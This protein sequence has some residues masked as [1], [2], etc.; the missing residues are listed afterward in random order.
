MDADLGRV[1]AGRYRLLER[2]GRGGMG[3][4]WHAHDDQLDRDVAVKEL[5]LPEHLTAPEREN[6]IARL[7]REAR[8]AAR[9]KHPGIITVH[10][11]MVSE[12]GRPWIVME[13]VRGGSLADLLASRERL[14]PEQAAR[15][16]LQVL[17]SL[18]AA[19]QAGITHRDV[20]PANILLEQDRVVLTDFGIAAVDGDAT[21]TASGVLLGTPAFMAPEQVRGLPATPASDLWSLGATLYAAVQGHPPFEGAN[22]GAVLV[23]VATEEPIPTTLA[24]PLE[25]TLRGLL[26]KDPAQRLTHAQ[27]HEL[28][29]RVA[30]SSAYVPTQLDASG[31]P[32]GRTTPTAGTEPLL[33]AKPAHPPLVP[34]H[35]PAPPA[36]RRKPG[37]A[38][39]IT[40]VVLLLAVGGGLGGYLLYGHK[41]ADEDSP[42]YKAN[43]RAA[44][45]MG[46]PPGFSRTSETKLGGDKVRE[47][48]TTTA[49]CG[50]CT[51]QTRTKA[52]TDWLKGQPDVQAV[53][54]Y[55]RGYRTEEC[56]KPGDCG[57]AVNSAGHPHLGSGQWYVKAGRL[58]FQIDVG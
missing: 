27:L 15:I 6:W 53:I 22:S 4:V 11:R 12:D 48:Y 24:G 18:R 9:L 38:A 16:G 56:H 36:P 37:R 25:A 50:S 20:K 28:L 55:P 23:A 19:H 44:H 34:G 13:L 26:H 30:S 32:S 54:L 29:S 46:Q 58:V 8:A 5:L 47:T 3:A 57:L 52:V 49:A 10:D 33:P 43:L 40:A 17:E 2:V 35:L 1:L 21:L 51:S 7:D 45:Q 39:V 31:A 41:N 14:L 42:A